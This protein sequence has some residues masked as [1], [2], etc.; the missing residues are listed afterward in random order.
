MALDGRAP[1]RLQKKF[2]LALSLCNSLGLLF[3]FKYLVFATDNLN[4]LGAALGWQPLRVLPIL[5][6]VG[7]SFYTFESISY[8]VDI[9]MGRARPASLLAKEAAEAAGARFKPGRTSLAVELHGLST[10]A[11][12]ISQFPHLV[13]GPIIRFQDSRRRCIRSGIPSRNSA[14]GSFSSAL[15]WPKRF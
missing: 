15:A 8:V 3:A 12:Y 6:P 10:F 13:A 9:Y 1:L 11:C 2:F 7:I 14:A 5:L 4:A